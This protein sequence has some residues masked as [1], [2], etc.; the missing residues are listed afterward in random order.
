MKNIVIYD[1]DEDQKTVHLKLKTG[2]NWTT[3]KIVFKADIA[4]V[5]EAAMSLDISK[6]HWGS[7]DP[8]PWG[9]D[10]IEPQKQKSID[11]EYMSKHRKLWK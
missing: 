10:E 8:V 11:T 5:H 4:T 1:K 6:W 9:Y 2:K 3:V 7:C